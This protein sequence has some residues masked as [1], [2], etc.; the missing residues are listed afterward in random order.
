MEFSA[1]H[2]DHLAAIDG[3]CREDYHSRGELSEDTVIGTLSA[4]SSH[5]TSGETEV[6]AQRP[7]ECATQ[8]LD[9]DLSSLLPLV[10]ALKGEEQD[11]PIK[12]EALTDQSPSA[13]DNVRSV[14]NLE[15]EGFMAGL[16]AGNETCSGSF[17]NDVLVDP[18]S[19]DDFLSL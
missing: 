18:L 12:V 5:N 6:A 11:V 4:S 1:G 19:L 10:G 7:E 3:A 9:C 13:S 17:A 16:A 2:L 15:D 8:K 14:P